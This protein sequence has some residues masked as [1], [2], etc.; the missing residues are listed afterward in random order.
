MINE[1]LILTYPDQNGSGKLNY[2]ITLQTFHLCSRE[3]MRPD[4]LNQAISDHH[5]SELFDTSIG[6]EIG[7]GAWGF[8]HTKLPIVI[9]NYR[10]LI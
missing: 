3:G 9:S 5:D 10:N 2:N 6:E 8:P 7:V 4:R 1:L